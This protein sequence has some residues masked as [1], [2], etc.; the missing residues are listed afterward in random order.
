MAA[1]TPSIHVFVFRGL[2]FG[3][4]VEF[5]IYYP[6]CSFHGAPQMHNAKAG[7]EPQIRIRLLSFLFL[8]IHLKTFD[9]RLTESDLLSSSSNKL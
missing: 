2:V 3:F 1:P 8:S 6:V 5:D 7:I 9:S 4:L